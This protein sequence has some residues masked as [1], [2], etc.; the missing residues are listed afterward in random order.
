MPT[1]KCRKCYEVF[2][3][4]SNAMLVTCPHCDYEFNP[5]PDAQARAVASRKSYIAEKTGSYSVPSWVAKA[6][7]LQARSLVYFLILWGICG[8]VFVSTMIR[9]AVTS[10]PIEYPSGLSSWFVIS[11]FVY[12]IWSTITNWFLIRSKVKKAG[13]VILWG[14]ILYVTY[15]LYNHYTS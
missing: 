3:V 4:A 6:I 12:A 2:D 9:M 11:L 1:V 8:V 14:I 13:V 5:D 10:K 15:T 7:Y